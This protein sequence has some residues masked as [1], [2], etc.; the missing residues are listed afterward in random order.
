[1]RYVDVIFHS[2]VISW[3]WPKISDADTYTLITSKVEVYITVSV[4]IARLSLD[5]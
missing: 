1:M 5:C 3:I 2:D 4:E